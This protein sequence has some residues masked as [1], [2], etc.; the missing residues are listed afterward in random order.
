MKKKN[1]FT[2]FKEFIVESFR[3][4]NEG[5]RYC[6]QH[7]LLKPEVP[8]FYTKDYDGADTPISS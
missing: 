7:N 6:I 2:R 1:L 5:I 8:S 4:Y 3:E